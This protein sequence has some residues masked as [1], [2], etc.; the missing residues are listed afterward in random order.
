[1]FRSP[2]ENLFLVLSIV[3]LFIAG[4]LLSLIDV[5]LLLGAI[6]LALVYVRIEQASYIGNALRVHQSQFPDIYRIFQDHATRLGISKANLYIKQDPFLNAYTLGFQT[7]TVILSSALV[8][9]LTRKELAFVLGHELG[10]FAAGHTKLSTLFNPIG[11]N[12]VISN[13]IFGFWNRKC[14]YSSDKC[15]L[16]LTKDIDS[17][18]S[19]L[20]KLA[21]GEKLFRDLDME[22]YIEQIKVSDNKITTMSETLSS[23]PY[24]TNRIKSLLVFWRES[25]VVS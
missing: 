23:H 10:H 12:N 24:I 25:F 1:M 15:G 5:W 14:E 18:I 3:S 2:N 9:Q 19:A 20:I 4:Y 8:E 7:C 22:G 16:I 17:S 6:V 13:F 11:T 21:I